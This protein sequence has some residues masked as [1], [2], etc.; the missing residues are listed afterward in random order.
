MEKR[1]KTQIPTG[2][3]LNSFDLGPLNLTNGTALN[4]D[5]MIMMRSFVIYLEF[6]FAMGGGNAINELAFFQHLQG[7]EYRDLADS[8]PF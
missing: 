8:L 3:L 7:P 4:A 1:F 5:Q 6:G 2:F